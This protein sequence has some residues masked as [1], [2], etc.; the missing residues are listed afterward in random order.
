MEGTVEVFC[1][2][3]TGKLLFKETVGK[4]DLFIYDGLIYCNAY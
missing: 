3:F 1:Y 2:K 4:L